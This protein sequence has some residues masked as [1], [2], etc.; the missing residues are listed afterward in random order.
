MIKRNLQSDNKAVKTPKREKKGFFDVSEDTPIDEPIEITRESAGEKK[1]EGGAAALSKGKIAVAALLVA[2]III[3]VSAYTV[4]FLMNDDT[5]YGIPEDMRG[6]EGIPYD[7]VITIPDW[8]TDIFTY[9]KYIKTDHEKVA[10]RLWETTTYLFPDTYYKGGKGF[11]FIMKYIDTIKNGDHEALNGMYTEEYFKDEDNE[12]H[13][14]FP[15]QKLFNISVQL[16]PDI[17]EEEDKKLEKS[18]EVYYYV[19][20]YNILLNDGY[21]RD[22]IDHLYSR[23]QLIKVLIDGNGNGKIH[24]IWDI[25]GYNGDIS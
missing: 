5:I 8:E 14:P 10:Y 21:F 7:P 9:D 16:R 13:E 15:M 17:Q 24:K 20:R 3:G 12:K 23:P 11:K 22:D 19:V 2:V 4:I 25:P 6:G 18:Y 1:P